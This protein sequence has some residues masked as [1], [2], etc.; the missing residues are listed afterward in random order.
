MNKVVLIYHSNGYKSLMHIRDVDLATNAEI[1]LSQGSE[2]R[3]LNGCSLSDVGTATD[4]RIPETLE[5][6]DEQ[7]PHQVAITA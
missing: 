6:F 1:H 7:Y 5:E 2:L 4:P 3:I